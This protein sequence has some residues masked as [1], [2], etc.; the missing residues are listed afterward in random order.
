[1]KTLELFGL[2]SDEQLGSC[3]LIRV[4][5]IL[6]ER[7]E[8]CFRSAFFSEE[9]K[10]NC[11]GPLTMTFAV[12]QAKDLLL[13][14]CDYSGVDIKL[15]TAGRVLP[16][17]PVQTELIKM[18]EMPD[19]LIHVNGKVYKPNSEVYGF[20]HVYDD[21]A[22]CMDKLKQMGF[23]NETM[24]IYATP[25][26]I[27]LEINGSALGL[28]GNNELSSRYYKL[29]C[30]IAEI[31]EIGGKPQKTA[32]K[33]ILLDTAIPTK[34][35]LLPG[36]I[37]PVLKRNKVGIGASHFSFGIAAFD[38]MCSKRHSQQECIQEALN[39]VKF[40]EK[41]LNPVQ[42]IRELL[43]TISSVVLPDKTRTNAAVTSS[44]NSATVLASLAPVETKNFI[45]VFQPL[46]SEIEAAAAVFK[47][48]PEGIHAFSGGLDKALGRGWTS[49]GLHI[50]L[51]N[52]ENGKATMLLQ[53]TVLSENKMPV[54]YISFEQNMKCFVTN[55]AC[56]VAG[57]NKSELW[58]GLSGNTPNSQNVKLA[59]GAAIDKLQTKLSQNLYFSGVEAGRTKF[60]ADEII[61]LASM[62][63]EASNK[64]IVIESVN[65]SDFCGDINTQLQKLKAVALAGN[66]T[67][68][69][70]IHT[71]TPVSKRPNI[72]EESDLEYLEK[73]QRFTDTII[74]LE[75]AKT[76]MRKFVAL[77]KGQVDPALVSNLEQKAMQLC[78]GRKL[79]SDTYSLARIIHNR[80]GRRDMFLYLYQP[81]MGRFFDLASV[82]LS[83]A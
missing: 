8:S 10:A 16:A 42:G 75:S 56:L 58:Q 1:M 65:E 71:N 22:K 51:G 27:T 76:N 4:P 40:N 24:A 5:E 77:I 7:S 43:D 36:S 44:V 37:H 52:R 67:I 80:N 72:I 63:P 17:I 11:Y 18:L 26:D 32:I 53:Q 57:I 39:W 2:N 70:S 3:E 28:E 60:D 50:I 14:G 79:K 47:G 13:E 9:G 45:G 35:I 46:K 78:G 25:D 66:L 83:R 21:A 15:E 74:N 41:Q 38:E 59:L 64:L 23:T 54:L 81:D 62:L 82:S 19:T 33:T 69:M 61:Q 12:R 29:T 49:G 6:K 20:Q 48:I 55:A 73:F 34:R 31:K 68:I 30:H